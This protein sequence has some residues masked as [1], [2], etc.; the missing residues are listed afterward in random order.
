MHVL[1]QADGFTFTKNMILNSSTMKM[2]SIKLNHI[3]H[4]GGGQY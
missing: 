3:N 4:M 2:Q 1:F